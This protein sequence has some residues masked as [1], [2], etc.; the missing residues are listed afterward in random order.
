MDEMCR[1]R[2][3]PRDDSARIKYRVRLDAAA[4]I[5]L[6]LPFDRQP[7]V[8]EHGGTRDRLFENAVSIR[9]CKHGPG[10]FGNRLENVSRKSRTTYRQACIHP[11]RCVISRTC[12]A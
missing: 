6:D 3:F 7:T 2:L 9:V 12:K 10:G 5:A 1:Q 8:F 11:N 4:S